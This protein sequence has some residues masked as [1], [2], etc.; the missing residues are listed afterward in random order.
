MSSP[1]GALIEYKSTDNALMDEQRMFKRLAA[2]KSD[3][4]GF[5]WSANQCLV[6]P[7]SVSRNEYF[8]EAS[9][10]SEALG[11]PVHVRQTG[12][13]VTP[14]GPGIL[15]VSLAF[16]NTADN[17]LSIADSYRIICN[18][19]ITELRLLGID[20]YCSPVA[21]AFCDGSYNVVVDGKK[22]AGTAQRWSRMKKHVYQHVI[23]AHALILYHTDLQEIT[24]AV[25]RLYRLLKQK[26][27]F[28]SAA[29]C[30]FTGTCRE[31]HGRPS[32]ELL[33]RRLLRGCQA[34]LKT[35]KYYYQ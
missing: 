10:A 14:Q 15:N 31:G 23:L 28:A 34:E 35:M 29:H 3:D 21:G 4:T 25:N 20:A 1:A 8:A 2:G 13:G 17:R 32:A 5:I 19:I 27:H 22:L 11:W 30:N 24:K 9:R 16:S 26:Q 6:V 18:P 12:G 7:H 33:G